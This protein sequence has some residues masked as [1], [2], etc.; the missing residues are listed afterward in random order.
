MPAFGHKETSALNPYSTSYERDFPPKSDFGVWAIRPMTSG[1]YATTVP[2]S[3]PPGPTTYD[4]EFCKKSQR[5]SSPER[6]GTASGQRNNRPHPTQSFMVWRLPHNYHKN[7]V[8]N[9]AVS[10]ELTNEKLNQ[11]T[12]RLC[13]STY[14]TDYLGIPQG[15]QVKSAFN[16]PSNWRENVPYGMESNQRTSYQTPF[17]Q[18]QLVVPVTRYGSNGQKHVPALAVVPTANK[19]LIGINGRTTYD[20]H[21]NDNAGPVIEQIRDVGKKLGV[22]ALRKHYQ[23]STGQDK[24]LIGKLLEEYNINQTPLVPA[25]DRPVCPTPP[26]KSR[27]S[28]FSHRSPTPSQ[29]S[30]PYNPY[31]A[32]QMTSRSVL[33]TPSDR[34]RG[35]SR[36]QSSVSTR[37]GSPTKLRPSVPAETPI[38]MPQQSPFQTQMPDTPI[39]VPY[40]P[41]AYLS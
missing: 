11:I 23:Q 24:E 8:Q 13:H 34:P 36:L 15:F 20:R 31:T 38:M 41:P 18:Q 40:T 28:P 26:P 12:R 3:Q 1:G 33:P 29:A 2:K 25:I 14:Q 27:G 30:N 16:L 37:R 6:A 9:E 32:G 7:N 10:E 19:R 21:Y 39:S 4:V 35:Q 5:P 17:Q 22:E